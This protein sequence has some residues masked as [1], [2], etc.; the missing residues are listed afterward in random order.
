LHVFA[1]EG[2]TKP[3]SLRIPLSLHV[4]A[5]EGSTKNGLQ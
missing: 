4:F 1:I 3:L 2:S 5:I